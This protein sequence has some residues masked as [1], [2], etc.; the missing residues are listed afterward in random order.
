MKR[1]AVVAVLGG[2]AGAALW[3]IG[4]AVAASLPP[5]PP[6]PTAHGWTPEP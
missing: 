3:I 4:A 1:L 2:L 6:L 5:Y